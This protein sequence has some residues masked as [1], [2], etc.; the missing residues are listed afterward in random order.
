[1]KMSESAPRGLQTGRETCC[2]RNVSLCFR[3]WGVLS[4]CFACTKR[5]TTGGIKRKIICALDYRLCWPVCIRS[6]HCITEDILAP[7]KIKVV[8][9]LSCLIRWM[10]QIPANEHMHAP[11]RMNS[12]TSN[13]AENMLHLFNPFSSLIKLSEII[14]WSLKGDWWFYWPWEFFLYILLF[15]P[16][17]PIIFFFSVLKTW[18]LKKAQ[19]LMKCDTW[20]CHVCHVLC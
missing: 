9:S 5:G 8:L 2:L 4:T 18:A 11:Q 10:S 13:T 7:F 3:V 17:F 6:T 16:K 14:S 15:R 19:I 20:V 1:M 12:L